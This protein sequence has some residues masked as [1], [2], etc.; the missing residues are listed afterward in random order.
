MTSGKSMASHE[1]L[2]GPAVCERAIAEAKQRSQ[3]P[4]IRWLTKIYYLELSSGD[5]NRLMI[6]AIYVHCSLTEH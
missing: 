5:I 2:D 1:E 4:V 3:R 6:R